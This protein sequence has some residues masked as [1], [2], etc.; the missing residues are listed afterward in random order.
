MIKKFPATN[1]NNSNFLRH[2]GVAEMETTIFHQ[3]FVPIIYQSNVI[4]VDGVT[5]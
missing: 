5:C 1:N 2:Q 4:Q 3:L